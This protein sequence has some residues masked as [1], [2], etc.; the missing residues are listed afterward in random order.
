MNGS[1]AFILVQDGVTSGAIYALIALAIL[2]VFTITRVIL[3]PQG[4]FVI[5]GALTYGMMQ[6]GVMPGTAWLLL[7][8]GCLA[9]ILDARHAIVSGHARDLLQIAVARIVFPALVVAVTLWVPADR[10]GTAGQIALC[11]ATVVPLGPLMYRLVFEQLVDASILT[12][13]I[14]AVAVDAALT[15]IALLL[16]G[17]EGTRTDPLFD[18]T[19]SLGPMQ[20]G[21]PMLTI[22]I[23]SFLLMLMLFV[24]FGR[25]VFGRALRAT[26]INRLGAQLVGIP[27]RRA[28]RLAFLLASLL[29]T[30]SGILVSSVMTVYFDSGFMI[31][32]K[33]FVAAIVGGLVSYPIAVLGALTIG[34]IEAWSAFYASAFKEVFVFSALIPVLILRSF[35][36]RE[37]SEEEVEE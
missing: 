18:F 21:A 1:I 25:T 29:G 33:G 35:L 34:L 24:F 31:G 13:L 26:A 8:C 12:L 4:Q 27:V 15:G 11:L 5:Y 19:F 6:T 9:A 17:S 28:G 36:T 37:T 20:F 2:I 10:L 16:F 23:S 14:V 7:I 22:V 32:L 3:V 30:I